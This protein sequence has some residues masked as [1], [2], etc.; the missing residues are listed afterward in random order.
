MIIKCE[1]ILDL[2]SE[3]FDDELDLEEQEFLFDHIYQCKKCL[4][5]YNSFHQM[6]DLFHS[7]EPVKLEQEKKKEFHRWLHIEVRQI[8]IK[9]YKKL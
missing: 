8:V 5:I 9:K 6:L 1:D 4:N 2:L 7:L 3:F